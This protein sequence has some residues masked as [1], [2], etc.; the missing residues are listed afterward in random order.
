MYSNSLFILSVFV[1]ISILRSQ[2][3]VRS[4][5]R[6]CMKVNWFGAFPVIQRSVFKEKTKEIK[7]TEKSNDSHNNEKQEDNYSSRSNENDEE[8]QDVLDYR[9][10]FWKI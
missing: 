3:K 9:K 4:S 5:K 8:R 10:V 2:S 6:F 7:P 1:A